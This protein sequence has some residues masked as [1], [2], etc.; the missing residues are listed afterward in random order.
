MTFKS[1][2]KN[3]ISSCEVVPGMNDHCAVLTSIDIKPKT[4]QHLKDMCIFTIKTT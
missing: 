1:K 4:E 2:K 3:L